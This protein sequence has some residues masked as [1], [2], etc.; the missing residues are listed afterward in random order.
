M[1]TSYT[2]TVFNQFPAVGQLGYFHSFGITNSA[3]VDTPVSASF[4][5]AVF[6]IY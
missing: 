6:E 2:T 4:H 5:F 1:D 3:T